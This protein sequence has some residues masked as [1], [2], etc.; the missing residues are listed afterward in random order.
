MPSG[1]DRRKISP[2]KDEATDKVI[3]KIEH[4]PLREKEKTPP[5][6]DWQ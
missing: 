4:K 6:T 5:K 1:G 2:E 3:G